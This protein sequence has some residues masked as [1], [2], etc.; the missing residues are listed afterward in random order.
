MVFALMRPRALELSNFQWSG[1]KIGPEIPA[2]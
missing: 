1:G 2:T